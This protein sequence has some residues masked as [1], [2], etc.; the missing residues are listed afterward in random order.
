ML[1]CALEDVPT[2][3]CDAQL[4][5]ISA[6]RDVFGRW[7]TTVPGPPFS[8]RASK[9]NPNP[10]DP[11]TPKQKN[12]T[13]IGPP[14]PSP[15]QAPMV[16]TTLTPAD[17]FPR[18]D[19]VPPTVAVD[20]AGDDKE[21]PTTHRTQASRT[22]PMPSNTLPSTPEPVTK[23]TRSQTAAQGYAHHVAV[24]PCL[25][26]HR[27]F[28]REFLLD[29]AMPVTDNVT[30]E[31]LENR[32]L[33]RHPKY[34]QIW[35]TSYSNK[36]GRLCQG[37]GKGSK[38]LKN[39]RIE[40]TDTFRVIRYNNIPLDRRKEIAY[41]NLVCEYREQKADPNRTRVTVGGNIIFYPGDVDTPPGLLEFVK[42]IINSVLS[43][44][45]VRFACFD[46]CNFYLATPMDR[47]EF[48]QIHI[49]DI[50]KYFISEYNLM[51]S[52]HNGWI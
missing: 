40:R 46:V 48:V 15:V 26:A 17:P 11:T 35:N 6:L 23:H 27:R 41:T 50:S 20:Q 44:R 10:M 33:R 39:Q 13:N 29:W 38:G 21:E 18:V 9:Q 3:M 32:Q 28:T 5:D 43:C 52:I 12:T 14:P 47:S 4:R 16:P 22:T 19:M 25:A 49:E 36:L 7:T 37:I 34:Q 2:E 24:E 45:N 1:T 42:L 30:G 51:P 31:T 8:H